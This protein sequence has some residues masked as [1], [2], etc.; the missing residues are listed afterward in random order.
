VA[1]EELNQVLDPARLGELDAL[2]DRLGDPGS[3]G[4][5]A[6]DRSGPLPLSHA[7][8]HIWLAERL[9]PGTAVYNVPVAVTLPAGVT[10][11][12]L[13][14]SLRELVRRHEVLRTTFDERDGAPVQIVRSTSEVPVAEIHL[15]ADSSG[16]DE[17]SLTGLLDHFAAE[18]FDLVNGPL[19]RAAL[20]ETGQGTT[21]LGLCV[22][23]LV[24]DGVGAD[25]LFAELATLATGGTLPEPRL[26]YGDF[27]VW[28]RADRTRD[29]YDLSHWEQRLAGV[30]AVLE[31]PGDRPRPAVPSG[32][33][34]RLTRTVAEVH[35]T[36]RNV[37]RTVRATP[38]AV[39]LTAA[40]VFIARLS[41][42]R[43]FVLGITAHGRHRPELDD[44]IG[45]FANLLP[46]VCRIQQRS[47]FVELVA[48]TAA[49]LAADLAAEVPFS[50]LLR[51][52]G[53][54]R[55]RN[56]HALV[57]VVF[58]HH[59]V[60]AGT[61]VDIQ[62]V[63]LD[64]HT[65]KFDLTFSVTEVG[66]HAHIALEY[67]DDLFD[68][69]TAQAL[70]DGYLDVLAGVLADPG[71]PVHQICARPPAAP[72]PKQPDP[73]GGLHLQ[74][75]AR[76][77][78]EPGAIAVTDSR[79]D[80]SYAALDQR[81][82]QV[83]GW[84]SRNG[85]GRGDLVG[86]Y[87]ERGADLIAG[88]LGI[89]YS[90]AAYVPVDPTH[91]IARINATLA[92]ANVRAV[93]SDA[94][95][96][97][98]PPGAVPVLFLGDV[99][100][101]V[102][103][104]PVEVSPDELAYVIHT[105]GSTG[106]PKG[107]M[108][109]HGNALRLFDVTA[110][111]FR[112]GA[113]DVW[114]LFH[115]VA[116]DFSVWE[117]WG[118]LLHGGRLVV[119][120]WETAR[121]PLRFVELLEE[122][123]VTVLSQTPSA[124]RE[125]VTL[126]AAGKVGA[127]ALRWVVFGGEALDPA[128]VRLWW[129]CRGS[130]GARLVNMY[131]ITETTV[132]VTLQLLTP[133][134]MPP[135]AG[136]PIGA[137][138]PDLDVLLLDF[139]GVAVPAGGIGEVYV[140][141]RGLAQGYLGRPGRTADRFVPHPSDPGRRLYRSGDLARRRSDGTLEFLGRA[142]AQVKIRGVR[143]ELGEVEA[144]LA[145]CAD[146]AHAAA[147]V[148]PSATGRP[149]LVGY[150]VPRPGSSIDPA[151]IRSQVARMLP[152]AA[153][154]A[155]VV[156]CAALPL[157]GN[158]KLD[159]DG[160]PAPAHAG[161]RSEPPATPG[162]RVLA[163]IW[164]RHLGADQ[165]T[166]TD[167]FFEL[168]GDSITA[169]RV[170]AAAA[171]AG[172]SIRL[173]DVFQHHDLAALAAGATPV[174]GTATGSEPFAGIAESDRDRLPVEVVDAYPL[175]MLQ[176]GMLYHQEAAGEFPP[177][178]NV[179]AIRVSAPVD[180]ALVQRAYNDVVNRHPI[181]RTSF[182]LVRFSEPLQLV[183]ATASAEVG[184]TDLSG[185][186]PVAQE[187]AVDRWLV[188]Q[189][190]RPLD[191]SR[192]PLLRLHVLQAAG[193]AMWLGLI[194]CHAILD[195]WSFVSTLQEILERYANLLD[196][197]DAV[198]A[199]PPEPTFRDFVLT[200]RAAMAD[201]AHRDFW[202][203]Q[204][205][206][207]QP[208]ALPAA[209]PAAEPGRIRRYSVPLPGDLS[210]AVADLAQQA[211][212]PVKS[213]LLAVHT[214]ALSRLTGASDVLTG[215]VT[216][217]RLAEGEGDDTRG[218]FLNTLPVRLDG[219]A[220]SWD[221]GARQAFA[222]EQRLQTYRRWPGALLQRGRSGPPLISAC[223]N[224]TS[225]HSLRL[226]TAGRTVQLTSGFR[227]RAHTEFPLLASFDRIVLDGRQQLTLIL[228]TTEDVGPERVADTYL[229]VLADLAAGR[230]P[231]E[232]VRLPR[233]DVAVVRPD[234]PV[235]GWSGPAS[236]PALLAAQARTTPSA[237][238]VIAGGRSMSYA[239]L[240]DEVERTAALLRARGAAPERTIGVF[241]PRSAEQLV[242]VL[243]VARAS[244]AYL[245][246]DPD[247][248]DARLHAA[249]ADAGCT[250]VICDDTT[251][252]R[253]PAGVP[254][255]RLVD[256]APL[257]TSL[258]D[259][260]DP[261]SVAYAIFTSGSTGRPKGVVVSH[262]ALHNRVKWAQGA[263]A[264]TGADRVLLK[265]P[266]GFDVSVWEFFWPLAAG[267]TTVVAAPGTHRD[268]AELA[269]VIERQRVTVVH[270]VPSVL[271]EFLRIADA[272]RCASL[273]LVLCSGEALTGRTAA[274]FGEVLPGVRLENLYG[275]T[276]AAIDV[277]SGSATAAFALDTVPI[278][279]PIANLRTRVLD[280][281]GRPTLIGAV[282]ELHIG[283]IG[284]ARGYAGRPGLTAERFVPDRAG[285]PG[286]RLYRTGDLVRWTPRDGIEFVGRQDDQIKIH[287]V[288]I[289]LGEIDA[290]LARAPGVVAAAAKFVSTPRPAIVGCVVAGRLGVDPAEVQRFAAELLPEPGRPVGVIVVNGL[291]LSVN[292]KLDRSRLPDL[293]TSFD[294][295]AF[296]EPVGA[297]ERAVAE[298]LRQA[299]DLARVGRDDDFAAL[300]G[301]SI[302]AMQVGAR[303]RQAGLA[304]GPADVIRERTCRR[305]AQ[306]AA[307][308]P[309][310]PPGGAGKPPTTAPL[311]PIQRWFLHL[312]HPRPERIDQ[313]LLLALPA[314]ATRAALARM[315]A[316]L[317]DRHPMLRS[318]FVRGDDGAFCTF[319]A[320][321]VAAEDI[322]AEVDLGALPDD[323]ARHAA[324][325]ELA[326][327][328]ERE[329]RLDTA[330]QLR[331]ALLHRGTQPPWLLMAATHL[332]LDGVSWQVLLEDLATLAVGGEPLAPATTYAQFS[333]ELA[334]YASSPRASEQLPY[335]REVCASPAAVLREELT[336]G[337]D[338]E[339]SCA[340]VQT[341]LSAEVTRRLLAADPLVALL[342]AL[343]R[344]LEGWATPGEA[345]VDVLGHGREL[346]FAPG[347]D[348]SRVVGWCSVLFP[349]RLPIGAGGTT[350]DLI[351]R[352]LAAVPDNGIGFG[353]LR[354]LA[355][356]DDL[357][358]PAQIAVNYVGQVGRGAPAAAAT[359][360]PALPE[361][362]SP[363]I[364]VRA[365]PGAPNAYRLWIQAGVVDARMRITLRHSV[366][367]HWP[368]TVR[369][370]AHRL[371]RYLEE[372]AQEEPPKVREAARVR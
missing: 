360:A 50:L 282:G 39:Y 356:H 316:A 307:S 119:V 34:T 89:L 98:L 42:R 216:N 162:E 150:V 250:A 156:T 236:M 208:Q 365:T 322:A 174:T 93:V 265:T 296:Q 367:R 125:L 81:A 129:Q 351:A 252:A 107:V 347:L 111:T 74:F 171:D 317:L 258:D 151:A 57:Q 79:G 120:D 143:V 109:T 58:T 82:R 226:S 370:L 165:V 257:C 224:Y 232:S 47:A 314:P 240:N 118:A 205:Q 256:T 270:F 261:D 222:A 354:H 153:T 29:A 14:Q 267:A 115:S 303:L 206:D 40:Q 145:A 48:T 364:P 342:A 136:T 249:I 17:Q 341:T 340:T 185:L 63:P 228:G 25:K 59:A 163:D 38:F 280:R 15:A 168:G 37:A 154:P 144:A 142:D 251:A 135:M 160:L 288:R 101:E 209:L 4:I 357:W 352:R 358:S 126:A 217:G 368:A 72:Q 53:G 197:R 215:L 323:T 298:V 85:V 241:L 328:W 122:Q 87:A 192:P 186:D 35:D 68:T 320:T 233:A 278:G 152:Q 242:A 227:E 177:Y 329:W 305:I 78:A 244:A 64:A 140:A 324:A 183:H 178:H 369:T 198:V 169:L 300:G 19:L 221:V 239:Q 348:L 260:V 88:L 293:P 230:Q 36:V 327:R 139:D 55:E 20:V 223:F 269:D 149:I 121:T 30:P 304:V 9:R 157:T 313:Y 44:C 325:R 110:D 281:A 128:S 41:G 5:P 18:P 218:L 83:A 255:V 309:S 284:L 16:A 266:F 359:S 254:V 46:V 253:A 13:H 65:A 137:A 167:N 330:P 56:R 214:V 54:A 344:T 12:A 51:E 190:R 285:A 353:A 202:S 193:D 334:R 299:L 159:R 114:T 146:V 170:V 103:V 133:D 294:E 23:H 127:L 326:W 117:I 225:F 7:Q 195:G 234:G 105:S 277:T 102:P 75:R 92:A 97:P 361:P 94:V 184:Y 273:R 207:M 259:E 246:L 311:A 345:V 338:D 84:L 286:E 339:P 33:G 350:R 141:G 21:V 45:T 337:P 199:P 263:Y 130:A 3:T 181:L 212:V 32:R 355:G 104:P 11:D 275:P 291:P 220:A 194:E 106:T 283:G 148:R 61:A 371:R 343:A 132:H 161:Q 131:G 274:R 238:A 2:L 96:T 188:E 62:H 372:L 336:A 22:H 138:L 201:P 179:T 155:M 175:A 77:L 247:Q 134:R 196:G 90:G 213:V 6:T 204:L 49:R 60:G 268:V 287:G 86:L 8:E 219:A 319:E 331:A 332:V 43:E 112:F 147:A 333:H 28:E 187:A 346:P 113:G 116:F 100:A 245:P 24:C 321:E 164:R 315:L 289:E 318:R 124:F 173:E 211:A 366:N 69:A 295:S 271:D 248:P 166:R 108:V 312:D 301:D 172:L 95:V 231:R 91:P 210:D 302:L 180:R 203:A 243:A 272:R 191:L 158:G 349:V 200:E 67:A 264:L 80:I 99:S 235:T 310:S 70:L 262:R 182:D 66:G 292:G 123:Q 362:V 297:G 276:E 52:F 1:D 290:A 71:E 26:Q 363:P 76:A 10:A 229:G 189:Q 308:R 237:V 31:I 306:L 335:W 279:W 27:A 176:A 73:Q